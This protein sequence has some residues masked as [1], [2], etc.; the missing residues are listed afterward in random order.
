MDKGRR[1]FA[2]VIPVMF[3]FVV[4]GVLDIVG[5]LKNFIQDDFALPEKLAGL[6]PSACFLWFLI[7][8]VPVG[9]L[10]GRIGRKKT[11]ITGM[12]ICV[13][14]LLLP[15][16]FRF[17][18][19]AHL[20]ALALLGIGGTLLVVGLPPLLCAVVP[21]EKTAGIMSISSAFKTL[22]AVAVPLLIALFTKTASGWQSSLPVLGAFALL[23]GLWLYF[24]PVEET[25][26]ETVT[27]VKGTFSLLKEKTMAECFLLQILIVG[28][29]IGLITFFPRIV[30]HRSGV[31]LATA[32]A[33]SAAYPVA[34]LAIALLGGALLLKVSRKKYVVTSL[35]VMAAGIVTTIFSSSEFSLMAGVVLIGA[36]YANLYTLV[37]TR[38]SASFP[39]RGNEVSSLMITSLAGGAIVPLLISLLIG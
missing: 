24:S 35:C 39:D 19:A 1:N 21:E 31:S 12:A 4:M 16:L 30:Q 32:S 2:T 3:G 7:L 36:G 22:T 10:M 37:Y 15:P 28:F 26:C 18:L 17:S 38:A 5:V 33:V 27:S 9:V 23:G 29:D 14:G 8:A 20:V 6:I 34:K 25:P 11:V 13:A